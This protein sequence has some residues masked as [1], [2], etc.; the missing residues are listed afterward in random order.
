ALNHLAWQSATHADPKGRDP[1]RTVA[2]A[3]ESVELMPKN[4][5]YWKTLGVAQYRAGDWGTA[6]TALEKSLALGKG[7]DGSLWCFLA[8]AHWQ[9]G[10]K[11]EARRWYDRA[12][13]WKEKS[14][15]RLEELRRFRAEAEALLGVSEKNK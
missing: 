10:D 13:K 1:H 12:V 5:D 2:M 11:P 9:A 4:A 6:R 8:M 15:T 3:R 14:K 7:G